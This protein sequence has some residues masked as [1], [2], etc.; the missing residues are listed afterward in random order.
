MIFLNIQIFEIFETFFEIFESH[1]S[2][3]LVQPCFNS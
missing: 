2:V 3:I 1:K